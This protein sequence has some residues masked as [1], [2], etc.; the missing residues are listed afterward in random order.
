VHLRLAVRVD[1]LHQVDLD[2]VRA[3]AGHGDVL[4]HVLAL[5]AEL[6]LERES[7]EI[8]PEPAQRELVGP[9]HGDLLES[10]HPERSRHHHLS[11]SSRGLN[12]IPIQ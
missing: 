6:A 11:P 12:L 8:D 1:R 7:Q 4:V 9:A 5:A 2:P 3:R 10:E